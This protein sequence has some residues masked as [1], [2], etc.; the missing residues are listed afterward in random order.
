MGSPNTTLATLRPDLG[1]AFEE[2]DLAMNRAG[3]I[4]QKVMPVMEVGVASSPFG[5][6]T[7]ESLLR[8]MPTERA[9][10]SG[11]NRDLW[12]FTTDSFA[13]T[14][15]GFEGVVDDREAKIYKHYF[16]SEMVTAERTRDVVLR[17]QEIR[18]AA[19]CQ[20]SSTHSPT[21]VSTE[22]STIATATPVNDVEARVQA[23]WA[24]GIIANCLVISW[25]AFR[26]LRR[27]TQVLDLLASSGAGKSIEPGKIGIDDLK[28]VF[29]LPYIYVGGGQKNTAKMGQTA[30]ISG[31]WS[32]EYASVLRVPESNDM[33]E[34]CFGRIFHYADDGSNIGAA[35]ESYRDESVR[36]NVIRA[37]MDTHEKVLYTEALE[38]LGNITA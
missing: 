33:R 20:N 28:T 10:G 38:L 23:L 8:S 15:H 17:N 16:D 18:I 19:L 35:M 34:P 14:E 1:G 6:V 27:C 25:K 22:W 36:G 24:K 2:Y 26:N 4:G 9:P 13:T 29:A 5:K 37:R 7:I 3:F 21:N 31:V 11:Y 12:E 30:S 32:D